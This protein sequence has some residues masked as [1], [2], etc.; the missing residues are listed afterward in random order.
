ML[1]ILKILKGACPI[2]KITCHDVFSVLKERER[3]SNKGTYG[4]LTIVAGSKYFRGSAALAAE[5]ALR[6]GCG[7]VRVASTERVIG[8]VSSK[9]SECIYLPLEE[10]ESGS[11]SSVAADELISVSEKSSAMLIGCGMTQHNDTACIVKRLVLNADCPLVLD[12]DALN[13]LKGDADVLRRAKHPVIIT[14][15]VGE[16]AR[17]CGDSLSGGDG[18]GISGIKAIK[19]DAG[20]AALD[21]ST[22]YNCITVLKDFITYI[23]YSGFETAFN[24][25]GNPGLARGG[26]GDVL[27][28]IISSFLSQGIDPFSAAKCGVWLHAEAADRCAAEK[29]QYGM[30]PSD[31]FP[32]I[33]RIFS[34][35]GR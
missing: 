26:S 32:Y 11:I 7:I 12:A 14:P 5:G 8:S 30:L 6:S 4:T 27:A 33:Q 29:S 24:E 35:N 25:N 16:M 3:D 17:L 20:K 19:A 2:M 15:H 18:T 10:N 13:V 31:I 34:E 9:L 28:G 23:A 22:K 21:F 1:C